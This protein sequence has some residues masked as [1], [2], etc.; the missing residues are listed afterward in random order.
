MSARH[1][2][3][4]RPDHAA[5][6]R[7]MGSPDGAWNPLP[8]DQHLLFARCREL[9]MTRQQM[10]AVAWVHLYTVDRY[11][12]G[13]RQQ[14]RTPQTHD[15]ERGDLTLKHM[16][17]YFGWDLSNAAKV[18]ESVEELGF[19][20]RD[21]KGV[22]WLN[23]TV[24]P[25][26]RTKS[27]TSERGGLYKPLPDY[28]DAHIKGL[29]KNER[30]SFV[31]EWYAAETWHDHALAQAKVAIYERTVARKRELCRRVGADLKTGGGRPR[32]DEQPEIVQL[33]FVLE[34]GAHGFVRTSE[35][36]GFV[37]TS[38]AT[39]DKPAAE[40]VRGNVSLLGFTETTENR[41]S[42]YAEPPGEAAEN[43]HSPTLEDPKT[44][45]QKGSAA[46]PVL[47]TVEQNFGPLAPTDELREAFA[48]L[49]E[50]FGIPAE[51]VCCAILDKLAEKRRKRY[52]IESPRALYD[53]V[54]A[55][56][57]TWIRQHPH[58]IELHSK[59]L[60]RA[61]LDEAEQTPPTQSSAEIQAEIQAELRALAAAKGIQ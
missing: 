26:R 35:P 22:F 36:D 42:E 54:R 52:V 29:S 2:A 8:P 45:P 44:P 60:E 17:E 27:E 11:K 57:P 3:A 53:F 31:Q 20:R 43:T 13:E 56:L 5:L 12:G 1:R 25:A 40:F 28:L 34:P 46:D 30:E 16:A 7:A 24:K 59:L 41:V 14:A 33:T 21:A 15:D 49:P 32:D 4:A 10:Q 6:M 50:H 9:Q 19:F 51:S 61:R 58:E 47:R 39:S 23:A 18:A 38:D 48:E 37:E 55:A